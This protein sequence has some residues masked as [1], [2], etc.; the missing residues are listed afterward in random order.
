M[1]QRLCIPARHM[2][3][4]LKRHHMQACTMTS[5]AVTFVFCYF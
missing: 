2:Q 3:Q 1:L 5:K 4:Y